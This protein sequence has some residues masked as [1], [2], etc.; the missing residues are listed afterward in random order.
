MFSLYVVLKFIHILAAITA[1]GANITY[2]VWKDGSESDHGSRLRRDRGLDPRHDGLQ[3]QPVG[4]EQDQHR[5]V[6]HAVT[7]RDHGR[8][9]AG[10]DVRPRRD[11]HPVPVAEGRAR[12]LELADD[13]E[14]RG[15]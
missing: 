9:V 11:R 13:D 1:V 4:P 3:A 7:A 2:G 6:D 14:D 12:N 8:R 10:W 15:E 5:P